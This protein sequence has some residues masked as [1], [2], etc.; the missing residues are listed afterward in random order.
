[1]KNLL[2]TTLTVTAHDI[3]RGVSANVCKCPVAR[4]A[5]RTLRRQVEV[6]DLLTVNYRRFDAKYRLPKRALNFINRFDTGKS[7]KPFTFKIGK[8]GV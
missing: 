7:V 8:R 2:G 5:R 4:A 1:M 3:K 6:C